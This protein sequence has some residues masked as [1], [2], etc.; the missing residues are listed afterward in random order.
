MVPI[1]NRYSSDVL[2][3]RPRAALPTVGAVV[4]RLM[5]IDPRGAWVVSCY[6]KLE[7]RDRARGKYLIKLK[8]RIKA[9]E[10]WLAGL[11]LEPGG[12]EA[13]TR[14]LGRVREYRADQQNLPAGGAESQ[15]TST[16][17]LAPAEVSKVVMDEEAGRVEVVVP[18]DQLS[19]AIGREGQNA[20]LAARLTGCAPR[21]RNPESPTRTSGRSAEGW[22]AESSPRLSTN[23]APPRRGLPGKPPPDGA[24]TAAKG[25]RLPAAILLK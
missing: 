12:R 1:A 9:R 22:Q 4:D 10:E 18:D 7:P 16:C 19:L 23:R 20:R 14:R 24:S 5:H 8:N 21:R 3:V 25:T 11:G 2:P 17:T 15:I 13:A 6:L